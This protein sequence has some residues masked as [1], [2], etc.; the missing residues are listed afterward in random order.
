MT[1][2]EAIKQL[3]LISQKLSSDSITLDEAVKLYEES[4]K[5]SKVC[6][7]T[8]KDVESKVVVVKK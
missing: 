2:E 6:F 5:L 4:T 3:E 8:L 7:E 1:Y